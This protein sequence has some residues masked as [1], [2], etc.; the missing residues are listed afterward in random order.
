MVST[1][2][3][4]ATRHPRG[5]IPAAVLAA[6]LREAAPLRRRKHVL[7]LSIGMRRRGEAWFA[8][9]ACVAIRVVAKLDADA[10][11]PRRAFPPFI[12]VR[13]GG[14]RWRVPTDVRSADGATAGQCYGH[15][16]RPINLEGE[17]EVIGGVSACVIT[18]GEPKLLVSGHVAGHAGRRMVAN[19]VAF[20]TEEPRLT[21]RLDH[22]LA[23]ARFALSEAALPNGARFTGLRARA[24]IRRGDTLF[25]F[26]ALSPKLH[27]V[28]VR[29]T[30]AD[31]PF[32]YPSGTWRV[33]GLIV[34]DDACARGDSGCPLFDEDFKLVGTLLGGLGE[35]YY[36]PADYAFRQLGIGLPR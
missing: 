20:V 3:S 33:H 13:H 8:D 14:R 9:E 12:E 2:R 28:V 25:V 21:S 18:T 35:D 16:A 5:R 32:A 10:L 7:G 31:A 30:D 15:V 36:L 24:T 27:E 6:A 22:C 34:V 17:A 19:G 29:D 23:R 11:H 4:V 26:R 1:W